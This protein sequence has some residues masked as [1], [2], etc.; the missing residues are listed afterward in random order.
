M[1]KMSAADRYFSF[2]QIFIN[3]ADN[4]DMHKILDKF[5][6]GPL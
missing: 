1:G 5:D 6:F 3:L 2:D 4:E